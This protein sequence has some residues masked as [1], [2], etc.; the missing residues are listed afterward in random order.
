MAQILGKQVFC[1]QL[2][3]IFLDISLRPLRG[4]PA[5]S[6]IR[7][8]L[9]STIWVEFQK[10]PEEVKDQASLVAVKEKLILGKDE[11]IELELCKDVDFIVFHFLLLNRRLWLEVVLEYG[12]QILLH[13]R[14]VPYLLDML[15]LQNE[16]SKARRQLLV[17]F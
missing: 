8:T 14:A 16:M 2:R 1:T 6:S 11:I 17:Q 13:V 4:E 5:L 9:G 15:W 12:Y 7:T 10:P 3:L